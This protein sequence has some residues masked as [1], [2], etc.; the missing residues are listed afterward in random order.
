MVARRVVPEPPTSVKFFFWLILG[1]FSTYLAE[2]VSGAGLFPFLNPWWILVCL[3]LYGL[4]LLVLAYVVYTY[5]KPR[6]ATLLLAGFIFGMYEAYMTKVVWRPDWG[7]SLLS[8]G[9]IATVETAL[10]SFF[11]HPVLAFLI[12]VVVGECVLTRSRES[13]DFLPAVIKRRFRAGRAGRIGLVCVAVACGAF[14]SFNSPSPA[15]SLL[16]GAASLGFIALLLFAWFRKTGRHSWA[17]RDLLP[18]RRGL[19]VMLVILLGYYVFLGVILRPAVIPG[20][21]PQAVVWAIYAVLFILLYASLKRFGGATTRP[22]PTP[23][24]FSWRVFLEVSLALTLTSAGLNLVP[25]NYIYLVLVFYWVFGTAGLGLFLYAA[26]DT[27]RLNN[28]A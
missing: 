7:P 9:G 19:L 12:P 26:G 22:G 18:H 10:I 13:W 16:S 24:R 3:P 20:I 8:F 23:M 1:C 17:M 25:G 6:F 4:H 11:W 5:G 14:Q 2:G 27:L 28:P 15:I 21:G